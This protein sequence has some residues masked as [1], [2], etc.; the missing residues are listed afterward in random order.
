M[1]CRACL[2]IGLLFLPCYLAADQLPANGPESN[3]LRAFVQENVGLNAY[4]VYLLNHKVGWFTSEMKLVQH[5][6]REVCQEVGE[7]YF[8]LQSNGEKSLRTQKTTTWYE[9]TGPGNI[10]RADEM[11]T[12]DLNRTRRLA[13]RQGNGILLT[14]QSNTRKTE[15]GCAAIRPA[16][17]SWR[18]I[19]P[20]GKKKPSTRRR[21]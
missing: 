18:R 11:S 7:Y 21:K 6:G 15:P 13:V 3:A 17:T 9:L 2:A 20:R 12:E 14:T 4:G 10:L 8:A 5:D 19:P 16:E 1:R